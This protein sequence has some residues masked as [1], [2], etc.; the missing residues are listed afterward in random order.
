MAL[1]FNE[2]K[3]VLHLTDKAGT[4]QRSR[5]EG[6]KFLAMGAMLAFRNPYSHGKKPVLDRRTAEEQLALASQLFRLLDR[7]KRSDEDPI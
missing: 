6:L 2:S 1:V 4:T 5:Q 3:P 7:T